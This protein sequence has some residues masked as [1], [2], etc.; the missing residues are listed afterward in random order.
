[1]RSRLGLPD[2]A[3]VI[4]CV[5]RLSRWKAQHTLVEAFALVRQRFP[6]A[7]LVLPGIAG[8][9][10]PDGHGNY[11]DYLV[12]RCAELDL[13]DA[14]SLPGFV[15]QDDMP[16]FYGAIDVLAHPAI[17]EPFGLVLVEA[18]ASER[19]VVAT[20]GGGIP[21]IIRDGCDGLLV[22]A[23][24]PPAMA[25][26]I[27]RILDNPAWRCNS[28]RL[29]GNAYLRIYARNA[30]RGHVRGLPTGPRPT[31]G[32]T[33]AFTFAREALS[34]IV[35]KRGRAGGGVCGAARSCPFP[36][37]PDPCRRAR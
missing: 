36:K 37:A 2:D 3:P 28:G 13:G 20:V 16:E 1:M 4:G 33:P 35:A 18:M 5:A 26:A 14:V 17:E 21:E 19:P 27:S 25:E 7:R 10:S 31:R 32:T 6:A 34:P 29:G 15:P 24:K 12:R 23:E 22:G 8:D 11:R 9:S 30:S